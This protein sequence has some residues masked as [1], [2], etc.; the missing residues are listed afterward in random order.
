MGTARG[1][2]QPCH[3]RGTLRSLWGTAWPQHTNPDPLTVSLQLEEL[4]LQLLVVFSTVFCISKGKEG[5]ENK[6]LS[7]LLE[8][9]EQRATAR[10]STK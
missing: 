3:P 1:P 4:G 5:K 9:G 10:A 2:P 6:E 7:Y 8:K